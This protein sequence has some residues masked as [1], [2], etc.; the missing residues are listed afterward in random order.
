MNNDADWPQLGLVLV[1]GGF[2]NTI[3]AKKNV[4]MYPFPKISEWVD[5]VIKHKFFGIRIVWV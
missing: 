4:S 3:L 5:F 2:H 1:T